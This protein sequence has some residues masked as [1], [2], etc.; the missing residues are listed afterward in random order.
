MTSRNF[1]FTSFKNINIE[2]IVDD[3]VRY[4]VFQRELCPSTNN[5]HTQGYLELTVPLRVSG[6]RGIVGDSSV[7]CE[8]RKGTREQA[9]AYCMKEETRVAGPWEKGLWEKGGQGSR[10]DLKE[11]CDKIIN[12]EDKKKSILDHAVTYVKY[13]KGIDKLKGLCMDQRST[14][15]E[16]I[17]L[18]GKTGTGKTRFAYDNYESVYHKMS[19]NKWWDGYEQQECILLDDF[20]KDIMPYR[21][22]LQ[23]CDRYPMKVETKGGSVEINSPT[24]VITSNVDMDRW[25]PF[26]DLAPLHRRV[27]RHEVLG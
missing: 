4:I 6:I 7:H 15:P 1:V 2:D 16:V 27:T 23:L 11:L 24:I 14:M 12:G 8:S 5:E 10:N 26:E 20:D 17:V 18:T 21:T 25:Y 19:G 3:R 13:H 22:L 9:R